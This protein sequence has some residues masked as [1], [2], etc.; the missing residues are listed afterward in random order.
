[1]QLRVLIGCLLIG[2]S[3]VPQASGAVL[4][5][6]LE[7]GTTEGVG[8]AER[9][10]LI[11]L[12]QGMEV[13]ASQDDV[14]GDFVLN[15]DGNIDQNFL[16]QAIKDG[17]TYTERIVD[18]AQ[19]QRIVVY[20]AGED[21]PVSVRVSSV[22]FYAE[23]DHVEVGLF[24][25]LDNSSSPPRTKNGAT[26]FSFPVVA[27]YA[28]MDVSTQRG[29]MPLRQTVPVDDSGM[30]Q[31][32]YALKPGETQMN[33]RYRLPYDSAS[34]NT[35]TVPLPEPQSFLHVLVLPLTINADGEDLTFVEDDQSRG[36]RVFAWQPTDAGTEVTVSL[37]GESAEPG[38]MAAEQSTAGDSEQAAASAGQRDIQQVYH[39]I[40]RHVYLISG[41]LFLILCGLA[42]AGSL[43]RS[44]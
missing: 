34:E 12:A 13:V 16:I 26:T 25:V 22:A 3:F 15:F 1:M 10:Q 31:L 42:Y 28:S 40:G 9:V 36:F 4:S 38:S 17:V 14:R 5:G 8:S 19:T 33:V 2:C 20:D 6:R 21:V 29:T 30:A 39:P 32:A 35:V 23:G 7:N 43:L 27:G 37:S 44:R 41:L 24:Y 11:R 18:P